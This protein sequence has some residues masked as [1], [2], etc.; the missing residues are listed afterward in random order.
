V[1]SGV[2][3]CSGFATRRSTVK[4]HPAPGAKKTTKKTAKKTKAKAKS[5]PRQRESAVRF[6]PAARLLEARKLIASPHGATLEELRARLDCGRHTAMRT[7]KALE[8]MGEAIRDE[9]EGRQLRY[10]IEPAKNDKEAKLSTSHVLA[11]AVAQ[12]VL[13]FLEG[14]SLKESFDEVVELLESS[15]AP[16]AFAE[17]QRLREKVVVVQDAPWVKIDRTDVVDALVTGLT[18]GERVTLHGTGSGGDARSFDFEPYALVLWKKGLYV[19]GYSHHHKCVRLF[20]LDKLNDGE[21]KRGETFEVPASWDAHARYAGSFGLFDGPETSVRIEFSP[22]VARYV[23]R[24]QWM[25]DQ[26]IEELADGRVVLT[27][28]VRGTNDVVTWVLGYGEHAVVREPASLRLELAGVTA[29]MAAAYAPN[30]DLAAGRA[31][32]ERPT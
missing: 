21:W 24:R 8:A 30:L 2:A 20:G 28:T 27:M 26:K 18:R 31:A 16:K 23:T 29:K 14:T 9:R 12:Q 1:R 32:E 4:K 25:P 7:V 11:V 5:R 13:D 6:G 17:L 19:P 22:K 3:S 15:L 10:R